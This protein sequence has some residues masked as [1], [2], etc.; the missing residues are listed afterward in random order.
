M[1]TIKLTRTAKPRIGSRAWAAALPGDWQANRATFGD[2][3]TG[4]QITCGGAEIA[5]VLDDTDPDCGLSEMW[6]AMAYSGG[7]FDIGLALYRDLVAA[8]ADLSDDDD[9]D[10]AVAVKFAK[11]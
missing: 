11:I 7:R 3:S 5:V 4:W 6:Y 1:K 9:D 8:V 10:D 2:C